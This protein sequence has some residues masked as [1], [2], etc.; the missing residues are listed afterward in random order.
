MPRPLKDKGNVHN[1]L[2]VYSLGTPEDIEY[3]MYWYPRERA[4]IDVELTPYL[5][6]NQ[7][8]WAVV[9]ASPQCEWGDNIPLAQRAWESKWIS[10]SGKVERVLPDMKLTDDQC[11]ALD[12]IFDDPFDDIK[13]GVEP[14]GLG[15]KTRAFGLCLLGKEEYGYVPI[16]KHSYSVWRGDLA[17]PYKTKITPKEHEQAQADYDRAGKALDISNAQAQAITWGICRRLR[18]EGEAELWSPR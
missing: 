5:H 7:K 18:A 17:I 9:V 10:G 12:Y 3:G 6:I 8:V 11:A 2:G 15:L 14:P 4:T 1:I 13:N 16:D